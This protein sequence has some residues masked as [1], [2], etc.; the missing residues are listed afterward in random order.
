[1][2]LKILNAVA[3][4]LLVALVAIVPGAFLGKYMPGFFDPGLQQIAIAAWVAGL[5]SW[6]LARTMSR[7]EAEA[8]H[9]A[10]GSSKPQVILGVAFLAVAI[11]LAVA[12]HFY[13][14]RLLG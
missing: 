9:Q 8:A 5:V 7:R 12:L 13:G 11:G 1:M 4:T 6:W 14:D 3:M 2:L 10:H